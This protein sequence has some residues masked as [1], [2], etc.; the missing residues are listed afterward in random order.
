MVLLEVLSFGLPVVSFDCETGSSEV[1]EGTGGRLVEAFDAEGLAENLL[2]FISH[3]GERSE[4]Q[5]LSLRKAGAA[6]SR[7]R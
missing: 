3:P 7:G 2:Y 1:L 5:A 6:I 4:V